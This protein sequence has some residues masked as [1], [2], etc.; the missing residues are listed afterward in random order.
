MQ[1]DQSSPTARAAWIAAVE[2]YPHVR[3]A[4]VKSHSVCKSLAA[5]LQPLGSM[6]F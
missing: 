4:L 2:K 1:Q 3:E 6:Y 5:V